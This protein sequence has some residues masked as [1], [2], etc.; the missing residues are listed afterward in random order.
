M[1]E[2]SYTFKIVHQTYIYSWQAVRNNFT[3][4]DS[5]YQNVVHK[6]TFIFLL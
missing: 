2:G 4:Y 3:L 5:S 1:L 6:I